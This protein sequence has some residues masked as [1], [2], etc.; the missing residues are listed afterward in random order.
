MACKNDMQTIRYRTTLPR[1]LKETLERPTHS[2]NTVTKRI[3]RIDESIVKPPLFLIEKNGALLIKQ[4][5]IKIEHNCLSERQVE[6]YALNRELSAMAFSKR[7][8][9]LVSYEY[10]MQSTEES[11]TSHRSSSSFVSL[12]EITTELTSEIV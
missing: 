5:S 12:S 8:N 1:I 4:S 10:D 3:A 7:M 11:Q 2:W 9:S 6:R